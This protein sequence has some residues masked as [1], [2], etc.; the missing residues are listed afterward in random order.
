VYLPGGHA[1]GVAHEQLAAW[2][3]CDGWGLLLVDHRCGHWH[4][5][6]VTASQLPA[7]WA[8]VVMEPVQQKLVTRDDPAL[9]GKPQQQLLQLPHSV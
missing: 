6:Q 1:D 8:C 4:L 9:L 3:G 2:H 7:E 5:L